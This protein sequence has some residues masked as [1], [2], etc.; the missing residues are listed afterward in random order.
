MIV[1]IREIA[2]TLLDE[3]DALEVT[4]EVE[5]QSR[6]YVAQ[7]AGILAGLDYMGRSIVIPG[8]FSAN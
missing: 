8:T 1:K 5:E 4:T 2:A 3:R 7:F 6:A